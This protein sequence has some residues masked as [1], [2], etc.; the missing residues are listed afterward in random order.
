ML[1]SNIYVLASASS[2]TM[3]K[4]TVILV[5]PENEENLGAIARVMKNFDCAELVLVNP[6]CDPLSG[7]ALMLAAN[8]KDV[9]RKAK[10]KTLACLK[11]YNT[12]IGTTALLGKPTNVR[13]A[14]LTP[15][16]L[17]EKL[18]GKSGKAAILIGRESSGLSN[19][20]LKKCDIL[21]TIPSSESYPTL[22]ISHAL[23]IML[24]E[25]TV[26]G[27]NRVT[28]RVTYATDR[29]KGILFDNLDTLLDSLPFQSIA[30]RENQGHIW[31][32]VLGKAMLTKKEAFG[33]IDFFKKAGRRDGKNK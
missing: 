32:R 12:V 25:L 13:R 8:A 5:E 23:A 26:S 2:L 16:Q 14:P 7:R 30:K 3:S 31:R 22:N 18:R 11:G 33:L 9:L 17:A 19:E 6:K 28:E 29:E 21:V 10:R 24:Y 4:L 1:S 27:A 20:E 15:R